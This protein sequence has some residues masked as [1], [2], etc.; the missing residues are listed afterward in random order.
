MDKKAGKDVQF[1]APFP[2]PNCSNIDVCHGLLKQIP[3]F[4]TYQI[5]SNIMKKKCLGVTS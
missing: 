2:I 1:N 4:I 3:N 5:K